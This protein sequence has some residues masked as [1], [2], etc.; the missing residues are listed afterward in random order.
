MTTVPEELGRE[1]IA[2]V[3]EGVREMQIAA[4]V[5]VPDGAIDWVRGVV[6]RQIRIHEDRAS[7]PER[8]LQ[9]P[10][11][12]SPSRITRGDVG[13]NAHA[14]E[15]DLSQSARGRRHLKP[16][17]HHLED[18]LLLGRL[19]LLRYW[20]CEIG[21]TADAEDA[22]HR[23]AWQ[24]KLVACG[25]EARAIA[26]RNGFVDDFA[27]VS[28]LRQKLMLDVVALSGAP[29]SMGGLGL[30]DYKQPTTKALVRL[31]PVAGLRG[32][33]PIEQLPRR[34]ETPGQLIVTP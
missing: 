19:Q 13:P 29:I 30:G 6:E 15:L 22:G 4:G 12:E 7:D 5:P 14:I 32:L 10:A 27:Q 8:T 16:R 23:H 34:V 28:A 24:D 17:V 18:R 33:L 31:P 25:D 9:A 20:P 21:C 2:R 11:H 26:A 3:A 1:A